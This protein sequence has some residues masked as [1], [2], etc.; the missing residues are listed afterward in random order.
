MA[1]FATHLQVNVNLNTFDDDSLS[2]L[3]LEENDEG[4]E[5]LTPWKSVFEYWSNQPPSEHLHIIVK[6]RGTGE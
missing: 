2:H 6:V 3:K 4:V 5:K 1:Y